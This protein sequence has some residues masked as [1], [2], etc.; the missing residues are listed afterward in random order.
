MYKRNKY[1]YD[2][3]LR[4]VEAVLQKGQSVSEAAREKGVDR[5]NLRLWVG[6]YNRYGKA[7]LKAR[8]KRHYDAAFKQQVLTTIDKELLSL[9]AACFRFNIPSES[10]I[11]NWRKAYESTGQSGLIPQPKGRPKKMDKPIKR[12]K[13]KSAKPLTR[14]EELLL[15]NEY[16]RAEN[17]LLKKLQALVQTDKKQKP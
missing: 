9:R 7:G 2:F 14:E 17:E 16:L 6:F 15:E 12:K 11:I 1:N 13:R 3:R 4:C 5:A 8:S 10:V